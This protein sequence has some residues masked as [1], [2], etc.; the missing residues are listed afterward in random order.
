MDEERTEKV[1]YFKDYLR[2]GIPMTEKE[3][4][5]FV[6]LHGKDE[7]K[8]ILYVDETPVG[9]LELWPDDPSDMDDDS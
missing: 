1:F 4:E 3:I 5:E 8:E 9:F 7:N 6:E 2:S